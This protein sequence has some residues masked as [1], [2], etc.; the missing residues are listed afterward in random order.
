[1]VESFLNTVDLETGIDDLDSPAR[2]RGWLNAHRRLI[3]TDAM[4]SADL[5]FARDLRDA[6]RAEVRAHSGAESPAGA[7]NRARLDGLAAQVL[8]RVRVTPEG[9][10]LQPAEDGVRGVLGEV[11]AAVVLAERDG[12]W[13]RLKIC[14]E[15]TCRLA[16]YDQSKNSSRCWC[17][18]S[19]CGNRSKTRAYRGRKRVEA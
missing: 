17:S 4:T 9:V 2:F 12:T 15:D 1:L 5:D 14:R 13:R 10:W 16:F 7:P 11:L 6:L 18:M 8:L 19:A 3:A